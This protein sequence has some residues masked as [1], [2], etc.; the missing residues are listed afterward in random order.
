MSDSGQQISAKADKSEIRA[1]LL[2]ARRQR[3]GPAR[4]AA[5]A[6]LQAV[7]TGLLTDLP[8]STDGP[9][10]A[11]YVP[12][13]S[14]PGGPD[15]PAVM[16]RHL[17]PT[18]RLILPVLQPD[19][20]LD[21]AVYLGQL[22]P[23]PKGTAEATGPRLGPHA[24]ADATL[25]VVPALAVDRRGVRLGK[26]GGS[27]DRALATVPPGVPVIALLYDDEL[28]DR[29]PAEPHD[30]PVTAVITPS[31]GLVRLPIALSTPL[32]QR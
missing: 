25:V 17:P 1:D 26:G 8:A 3:S 15:L 4:M 29:L 27:Y 30:R 10:V 11:G 14:E 13:G 21:W 2:A 19:L 6:R 18:G 20:S 23:G 32:P 7:L 12:V 28:R 5:A 22:V 16:A 24:L 9:V 31:A